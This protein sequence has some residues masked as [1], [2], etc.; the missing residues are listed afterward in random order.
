MAWDLQKPR[1][2]IEKVSSLTSE[3][4]I[5]FKKSDIA[6]YDVRKYVPPSESLTTENHYSQVESN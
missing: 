4:T 3:T 5:S 6:A 1:D 2:C